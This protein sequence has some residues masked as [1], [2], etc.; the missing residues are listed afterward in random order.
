MLVTS[1]GRSWVLDAKWKRLDS[2]DGENR[3]GLSQSDFYQ[4][5]AYGEKYL[6]GDG[7]LI[8][9]Y[10]QTSKFRLPLGPF[11][12]SESMQLWAVPFDV[13]TEEL[14]GWRGAPSGGSVFI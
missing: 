11:Q 2:A 14:Y 8:L 13:E 3:F 5:F 4:L 7:E 1:G 6:A 9:V 12:F 10:P